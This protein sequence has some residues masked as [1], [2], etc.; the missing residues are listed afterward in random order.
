MSRNTVSEAFMK[1]LRMLVL[2]VVLAAGTPFVFL[3]S[4]SGESIAA[5]AKLIEADSA[6]GFHN[7]ATNIDSSRTEINAVR[8]GVR[9]NR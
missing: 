1:A 5:E 3:L 8:L 2:G 4:T 6:S 7:T 9:A